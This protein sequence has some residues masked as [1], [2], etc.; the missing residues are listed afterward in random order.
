MFLFFAIRDKYNSVMN[1]N[2]ARVMVGK[3]RG[4]SI[5]IRRTVMYSDMWLY[6]C[7]SVRT[8][9]HRVDYVHDKP[10]MNSI[11]AVFMR[12]PKFEIILCWRYTLQTGYDCP[13]LQRLLILLIVKHFFLQSKAVGISKISLN[14]VKEVAPFKVSCIF[15][16]IPLCTIL[17]WG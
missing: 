5:Y 1:T 11:L 13:L 4:L 16:Q 7:R 17:F 10:H 14:V 9:Y 2:C 15:F 8:L 12:I 3:S 6:K